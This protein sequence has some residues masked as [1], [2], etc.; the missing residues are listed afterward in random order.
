MGNT[1]IKST[2]YRDRC[3]LLLSELN[4]NELEKPQSAGKLYYVEEMVYASN[5]HSEVAYKIVPCR[6]LM[7][8]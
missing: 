4:M 1:S 3:K 7:S 8:Q 5:S 2:F 6:V